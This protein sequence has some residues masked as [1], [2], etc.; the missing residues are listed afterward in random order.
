MSIT[1]A[2]E[3][4]LT[5]EEYTACLSQSALGPARP[6]GN[7]ERVQAYLDSSNIVI[8]ARD[9]DGSLVGVF[10]G[11]TDWH[12]ICYCADLAVAESRQGQGIG[13][14]LMDKA[15][16]ILGPGC[17]IALLS[18]PGAEGFYQKIG[19]T[20]TSAAFYRDRTDRS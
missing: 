11:V 3:T 15:T 9:T 13:G 20:Q 8:T 5:A 6:L 4:G 19:L 2:Q 12:W 7:S 17:T 1:C 10:R 14:T 16:E 18:L